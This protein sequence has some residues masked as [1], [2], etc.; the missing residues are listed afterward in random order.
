M[1]ISYAL[2]I[3]LAVTT[4]SLNFI[5]SLALDFKQLFG[6][7]TVV[8]VFFMPWIGAWSKT[9]WANIFMHYD[10]SLSEKIK[11]NQSAGH[12]NS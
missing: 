7:I 10:D 6:L 1:Y 2:G 9:I 3:A 8:L 12:T 11:E 5:F 4:F